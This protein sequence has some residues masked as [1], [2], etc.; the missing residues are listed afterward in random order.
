[1]GASSAKSSAVSITESILRVALKIKS[2][3]SGAISQD[4]TIGGMYKDS[5]VS[6]NQLSNVSILS[7]SKI[8]I[9]DNFI[10]NLLEDLKQTTDNEG[11]LFSGTSAENLAEIKN[12]FTKNINREIE[13]SCFASTAQ[14]IKIESDAKFLNS[15]IVVDQISAISAECSQNIVSQIQDLEQ[16]TK[17]LDSSLTNKTSLMVIGIVAVVIVIAI[18]LGIYYFVSGKKGGSNNPNI[19]SFFDF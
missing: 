2:S 5:D 9:D 19:E 4:V 10:K 3:S 14:R 16:L 17:K 13:L 12:V 6:I 11:T 18:I 7:N 1:M 15:G 8:V